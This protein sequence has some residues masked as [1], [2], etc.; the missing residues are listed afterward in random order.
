MA[1][2]S[3]H[4]QLSLCQLVFAIASP[5]AEHATVPSP[6]TV[7]CM[8]LHGYCWNVSERWAMLSVDGRY[9][10]SWMLRKR[11]N[12]V[13]TLVFVNKVELKFKYALLNTGAS[14]RRAL[15]WQEYSN[16]TIALTEHVLDQLMGL[17]TLFQNLLQ[18]SM[19]YIMLLHCWF[20]L[21]QCCVKQP[22]TV[23]W[24]VRTLHMLF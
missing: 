21:D 20:Q 22:D 15:Y 12:Y 9:V 11:L 23:C 10:R 13:W 1:R 6:F 14:L 5:V 7:E 24:Y 3:R 19:C 2:W 16:M 17:N 18:D 4:A 8:P